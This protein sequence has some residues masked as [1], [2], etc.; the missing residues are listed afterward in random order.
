MPSIPKNKKPASKVPP[1]PASP[2]ADALSPS[3]AEAAYQA[4]VPRLAALPRDRLLVVNVEV[5]TAAVFALG[6][7]RLVAEPGMR[8]RFA[9]LAG[10]AGYDDAC[11]QELAPAA[12]AAW[13]AR[14]RLTLAN[15]VR[16]EARLPVVLVEE[17]T[18]LRARLLKL[19][20][21]WLAED[22]LIAAE[23]A[24]I[25]VGTGHQDLANDLIALASM[26]ERHHASV[27]LD[28]KLYRPDDTSRAKA[29]SGEI[30]EQLGA[31][32]TAEQSEWSAALPRV[33]T[34]LLATYEEVRRGAR[35]LFAHEGADERF[36]S[37]VAVGRAAATRPAKDAAPA[38]P[39][40]PGDSSV[41][42]AAPA[43]PN[44]SSAAPA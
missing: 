25:R 19:V 13:Y 27:S 5:Q 43:A 37:L 7:S 1:A 17:A 18:A 11:T 20:D 29:L 6:I 21:Y 10:I 41:A 3:S 33:W 35:F 34:H 4:L 2:P 9:E 39:A 15:A 31:T 30:L 23:I 32:A 36:P 40:V 8:A 22:A 12:Q 42:P 14:H 38:E 44:G 24:A 16:T 28:K 26:V